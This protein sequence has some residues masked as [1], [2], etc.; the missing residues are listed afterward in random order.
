V[1]REEVDERGYGV[2]AERIVGEIDGVELR[3]GE[4]RGDEVGER[5]WDLREETRREDVGKVCDLAVCQSLLMVGAGHL[6]TF[7]FFLVLRT[8]ASASLASTPKVLP[9]NLT[10][11]T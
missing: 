7:R 5:G 2:E 6:H 9:K 4:E 3:E 8:W 10:S 1:L 11:S